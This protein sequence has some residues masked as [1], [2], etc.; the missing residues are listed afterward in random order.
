M[1]SAPR[2]DGIGGHPAARAHAAGCGPRPVLATRARADDPLYHQGERYLVAQV[3][4]LSGGTP[5]RLYATC[6]YPQDSDISFPNGR[7]AVL[8][9]IQPG[10]FDPAAFASA[11]ADGNAYR[12][13]WTLLDGSIVAWRTNPSDGPIEEG[14]LSPETVRTLGDWKQLETPLYV[15]QAF[16]DAPSERPFR[17]GGSADDLKQVFL[18]GAN[19][20]PPFDGILRQGENRLVVVYHKEGV[21]GTG[22]NAACFLRLADPATGARIPDIAYRAPVYDV[23]TGTVPDQ[24]EEK[25]MLT[26]A[27]L[28]MLA[29]GFNQEANL[30]KA[31][32]YCRQAAEL[33]ADIA[34]FPEMFNIGYTGFHGNDEATVAGWQ[35]R[36]VGLDSPWVTHFRELA[37]ELDMALATAFL[38][39]TPDGPRN[40]VALID[41]HGEI[42]FTYGKIHTCDFANFEAVCTPGDRFHVAEL[43]TRH[44]PVQVGAMIC[45]DREFPESARTLMLDGAEIV[46]TPNACQLD[47][48][49]LAQFMT[50][51]LENSMAVFMTNYP[52][53]AHGGRSVAYGPNGEQLALAGPD[54]G[55]IIAQIDLAYLRDY[56]AKTIWGNAFRRPHKYGRLT[57]TGVAEVFRRTDALGRPFDPLQR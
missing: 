20:A 14:H 13:G 48:N 46:L 27:L 45:Y 22:R 50:R 53:P 47:D 21:S 41:R 51:A 26:I 8:G 19:L 57:D 28:Q 35:A 17:V 9:P 31:D 2:V 25:P 4:F 33:G 34:L 24:P 44:G 5:G 36:A 15:L 39:A 1:A 40:S 12:L 7:F 49:R 10:H 11:V 23:A 42:R 55:V 54:E 38:E 30:T 37:K 56:R 18:N 43:D 52:A 3:D 32:T 29:D 16:V 6:S